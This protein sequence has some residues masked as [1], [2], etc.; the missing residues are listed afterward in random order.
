MTMLVRPVGYNESTVIKIHS[1]CQCKCGAAGRCDGNNESPCGGSQ[2][3]VNQEQKPDHGHMKDSSSDPNRNCKAD[4]SNVDCSGRGVCE[5]GK[6]ACEQ[7]RLGMV[8]GKYCEMDDFSCPYEKGQMCGGKVK[9]YLFLFLSSLK[10]R[11][12]SF[13]SSDF[14]SLLH[15]VIFPFQAKVCVCQESVCARMAGQETVVAVPP[16]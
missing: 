9:K 13:D 1:K 8:Y 15:F 7:S 11:P 12:C 4:G 2:H 3:G 5:C 10:I 16:P 14:P 6:C